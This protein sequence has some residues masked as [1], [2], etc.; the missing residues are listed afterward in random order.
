MSFLVDKVCWLLLLLQLLSW[1]LHSDIVDKTADFVA[2][3]GKSFKCHTHCVFGKYEW[4]VGLEFEDRIRIN[5][6][7]NAKFN[8][9]KPN[10]PYHAYYRHKI[11]EIQEGVAQEA[12]AMKQAQV[13]SSCSNTHT[14]TSPSHASLST[15][16]PLP[17]PPSQPVPKQIPIT[18][19]SEPEPPKEP[20]PDLEFIAE[21]P[22]IS[23]MELW[24]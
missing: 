19:V 17:Y 20:P 24:A 10:D 22:S 9:L 15:P 11:T 8:F 6:A 23:S 14:T 13:W 12:A 7:G 2:R 5:E 3:N 18:V 4:H 1:R 21:P 16:P